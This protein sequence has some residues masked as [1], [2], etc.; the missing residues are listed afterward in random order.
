MNT[1]VKWGEEF[2]ANVLTASTQN[3]PAVVALANGGFALAYGDFSRSTDEGT[4][5]DD[6][7]VRLQIHDARGVLTTGPIQ[8][9][10][11]ATGAQ[12]NP[13]ILSLENGGIAVLYED[14]SEGA[15]T[16]GDDSDAALRLSFFS[17]DGTA[18]PGDLLAPMS[19]SSSQTRGALAAL[20][21]GAFAFAYTDISGAYGDGDEAVMLSIRGTSGDVIV[22]DFRASVPTL[23]AQEDPA[24]A[25]LANGSIALAYTDASGGDPDIRVA[26]YDRTGGAIGTSVVANTTTQHEQFA[27]DIA[28]LTNGT[29][30]VSWTDGSRTG[31]DPSSYGV[32]AQIFSKHG[33]KLG[34]EFLVNTAITSQQA[35]PEVEAL[36]DGRFVIAW[37][38]RSEGVDSGLDD[39]SGGA[40]RAQIFEPDGSRSG[41]EFLVNTVTAGFQSDVTITDLGDGRILF[42]YLDTSMGV[43]TDFD[44][45]TSSIRAT[46]FDTRDA[47]QTWIGTEAHEQYA[48][49]EWDDTLLGRAGDDL[50]FGYHGDDRLDGETGDDR[51]VGG[52]GGDTLLGR[53]GR[54]HIEAGGGPD[55][56]LG[57][58]GRDFMFGGAGHDILRGHEAGDWLQ[59]DGGRDVLFGGADPDVFVYATGA[60]SRAGALARDRIIGFTPGEDRIV[61]R[62]LDA[63]LLSTDNDAFVFIG[64]DAF[65]NTPGELRVTVHPRCTLIRGD[66]DGDGVADLEILLRGQHQLDASDFIL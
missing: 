63:D 14:G 57:G 50:L 34:G 61:L 66:T 52:Q 64:E 6:F 11:I 13:K 20:P 59:G 5:L 9:N 54:D 36:S 42:A 51:L 56:L 40:I 62:R 46:I 53:E 47:G 22:P 27:A 16:A 15:D 24:L 19:T 12:Q 2:L 3:Q 45:T 65:S 39:A 41:D 38:D 44:D 26:V 17:Q 21:S 8:V 32:R 29:F 60:D 25:T 31:L 30:V 10:Q 23:G 48:G 58:R 7:A 28:G 43:Q 33:V 49:T 18:G 37:L 35:F 55:R 1:P 4:D